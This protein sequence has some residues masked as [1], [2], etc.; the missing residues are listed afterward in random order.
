MLV[1]RAYAF[2]SRVFRFPKNFDSAVE[3]VESHWNLPVESSSNFKQLTAPGR[4]EA[5]V[6]EEALSVGKDK[7]ETSASP[8]DTE[9]Y[10]A[11][12]EAIADA[13]LRC[14]LRCT[15]RPD[16][17][18]D[19]PINVEDYNARTEA[20]ADA[21]PPYPLECNTCPDEH[22]ESNDDLVANT[23]SNTVE[24]NDP[25]CNSP[26]DESVSGLEILSSCATD[27]GF[28]KVESNS[29]NG[30]EIF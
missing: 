12:K 17:T 28:E 7:A 22:L 9:D 27:Y 29:T 19:E 18:H 20:L 26:S 21:T 3:D 25:I 15:T 23:A 6:V 11:T 1:T 8:I 13:A 24:P 2:K 30:D 5:K 4:L 16:Q 10:N 14:P